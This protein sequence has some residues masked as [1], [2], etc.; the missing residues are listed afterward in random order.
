MSSHKN[1]GNGGEFARGFFTPFVLDRAMRRVLH[2]GPAKSPGGMANVIR[3]LNEHPPEGWSSDIMCTTLPGNAMRKLWMWF[4]SLQ[5]I[6]N[7]H[8]DIVHIHCASDWSLRRKKSIAKRAKAPVVFHIHS[9][10]FDA[11]L[12]SQLARYHIVTLTPTWSERLEPLIGPSTVVPN[13]VDPLIKPSEEREEFVLLMG[14]PDPVKGHDFAFSLGLQNLVVTGVTSAP[15]GVRA[16]GWVSEEK[17]RELLSK[18]KVL[19]VPSQFEGQPLVI[20]EALA[21]NCP[22]VASDTIVD[23]PS[24]VAKARHGDVEDWK[25][26]LK[27]TKREDLVGSVEMH[28]IDKISKKWGEIYSRIISNKASTD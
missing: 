18:A 26:A 3:L 1:Q 7:H 20:L 15:A 27:D 24:T 23:L 25:K 13:P 12:K 5:R 28:Q 4:R 14:R 9:G 21:S 10:Q 6:R 22:V 2:V 8:A 11:S 16:L 19:I 17:K